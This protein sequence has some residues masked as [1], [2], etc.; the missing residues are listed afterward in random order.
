[1]TFGFV[2]RQATATERHCQW[3]RVA[4]AHVKRVV[5][6]AYPDGVVGEFELEAVPRDGEVKVVVRDFG[7]GIQPSLR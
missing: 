5:R 2:D 3:G 1:V 6:H 7:Q 4:G